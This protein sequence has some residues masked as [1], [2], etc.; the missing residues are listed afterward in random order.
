M[1]DKPFGTSLQHRF[2]AVALNERFADRRIQG[3]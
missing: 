1:F 3:E 2:Q